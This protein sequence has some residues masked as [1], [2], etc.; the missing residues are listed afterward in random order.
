MQKTITKV[1][2]KNKSH[3]RMLIYEDGGINI[4]NF[5]LNIFKKFRKEI[6][7]IF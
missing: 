1:V 7:I 5:V 3:H 6:N 4:T 2:Y